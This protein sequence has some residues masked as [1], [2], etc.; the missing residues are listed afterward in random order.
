MDR[1]GLPPLASG[2]GGPPLTEAEMECRLQTALDLAPAWPVVR[3]HAFTWTHG[4]GELIAERKRVC[5]IMELWAKVEKPFKETGFGVG[6]HIVAIVIPVSFQ[7]AFVEDDE[8]RKALMHRIN[9]FRD[10]RAQ[11]VWSLLAS[12]PVGPSGTTE[13]KFRR[14]TEWCEQMTVWYKII[15]ALLRATWNNLLEMQA[16]CAQLKPETLA[17]A[18]R[19]ASHVEMDQS[20]VWMQA[21]QAKGE[22]FAFEDPR[23]FLQTPQTLR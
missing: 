11:V 20:M 7:E 18:R 9:S 4:P 5:A 6:G 8:A 10:W 1:F 17:L 12:F 16:L 3:V 22:G 19:C 14:E 21:T 15:Q 23:G 2:F 13:R